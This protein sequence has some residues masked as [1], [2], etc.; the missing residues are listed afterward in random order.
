MI[1]RYSA[2]IS[3]PH[4]ADGIVLAS[5]TSLTDVSPT[6]NLVIPANFLV[7]GMILS[8]KARGKFSN[9]GTP[10]LLLGLYY[11]AVA[12]TKL[13]ATGATTTTTGAT[14]WPFRLDAEI[15]IRSIGASGSAVCTGAVNLAASLA[16]FGTT[17]PIDASAVAA[18]SIDTTSAKAL[19]VG[20]QW[21]TSSASNTLTCSYM[22][23]EV[24]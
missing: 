4:I 21:G 20:A 7:P 10:T 8:V 12:G 17:V 11:G 6:P 14:N 22:R 3:P 24:L 13:A 15:Q 16:S 2:V 9:T 19:T 1:D 5:S 18:V 23:V